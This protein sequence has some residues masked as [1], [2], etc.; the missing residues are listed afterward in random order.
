MNR[1]LWLALTVPL[2][3]CGAAETPSSASE[4]PADPAVVVTSARWEAPVP[5]ADA[6]ERPFSRCS[7]F[8]T[9]LC[10][11]FNPRTGPAVAVNARGQ[12]VA[13]WQRYEGDGYRLVGAR[14]A[15]GGTWSEAQGLT[16]ET[17]VR[18]QQVL[19]D[20]RGNAVAQWLDSSGALTSFG[21]S[22]GGWSPPQAAPASEELA[23]DDAGAVH[24]VYTRWREGLFWSRL[25]PGGAWTG[26]VLLQGQGPESHPSI[27][28]PQLA[29][30]RGGVAHAIWVREFQSSTRAD[31]WNEVWSSRM[32]PGPSAWT[33]PTL[34][35]RFPRAV[36]LSPGLTASDS[37]SLASYMLW[38]PAQS[39]RDGHTIMEQHQASAAPA[40]TAP[41]PVS[42]PMPP[43]PQVRNAA[44]PVVA[45]SS[46]GSLTLAWTEVTYAPSEP[47]RYEI[48]ARRFSAAQ[49]TWEHAQLIESKQGYLHDLFEL[50]VAASAAG[51][52]V[53]LWIEQSAMDFG[54]RMWA[55]VF[56]PGTGWSAPQALRDASL[57]SEPALAMDGSGNAIVM[58]SEPEGDRTRIWSARLAAATAV[59]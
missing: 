36:A 45:G 44:L 21:S 49:G 57:M 47:S 4:P 15:S 25:A 42:E 33:E 23:M 55:S 6:G 38:E 54:H 34:L 40:W 17:T 2:V 39:G 11:L 27:R 10:R 13:L 58:W 41:S 26:P 24:T 31:E 18:E 16:P 19:I 30:T 53:V 12:T 29:L 8:T 50:H 7:P 59:R 43:A 22:A 5:V 28:D 52:A 51:N 56:V 20:A 9:S 1:L 32:R 3:A 48:R 35:A 14:L 37:G 46:S